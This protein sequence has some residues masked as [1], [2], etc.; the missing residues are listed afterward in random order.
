[1]KRFVRRSL[2]V[3]ITAVIAFVVAGTWNIVPAL[4]ATFHAFT[5]TQAAVPK[6]T[7]LIGHP[8]SISFGYMEPGYSPN[9]FPSYHVQKLVNGAWVDVPG[10]SSHYSELGLRIT[11]PASQVEETVTYRPVSDTILGLPAQYGPTIEVETVSRDS[12]DDMQK[13]MY[14]AIAPYCPDVA[15]LYRD[16]WRKNNVGEYSAGTNYITVKEDWAATSGEVNQRALA[17]HECGHYMQYKVYKDNHTQLEN[18]AAEVFSL[19]K[20]DPIEHMADCMAQSVNPGGFMGYGGT[21]TKQQLV[22]AE[23]VLKGERINPVPVQPIQQ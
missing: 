7:V 5:L 17:L 14:E 2:T 19:G 12:A 13:L 15:I 1:M 9:G 23:Q 4:G 21:C 11:V 22:V 20:V 6:N 10:T 16:T 18:D 8:A 3:L